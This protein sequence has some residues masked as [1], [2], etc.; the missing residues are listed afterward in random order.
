MKIVMLLDRDMFFFSLA[1][2]TLFKC[3][4]LVMYC[5]VQSILCCVSVKLYYIVM[6]S[7]FLW[8][9]EKPSFRYKLVLTDSLTN[10][11]IKFS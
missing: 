10:D 6:F 2:K 7:P 3:F 1:E 8:L 9:R 5:C 4:S 11:V